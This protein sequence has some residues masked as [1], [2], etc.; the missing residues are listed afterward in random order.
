MISFLIKN[1]LVIS[2]I[3][4]ITRPADGERTRLTDM[5][6]PANTETPADIKRPADVEIPIDT[7]KETDIGSKRLAD[8]EKEVPTNAK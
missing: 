8:A 3:I 4:S 7:E 2:Y 5:V 1:G 6:K